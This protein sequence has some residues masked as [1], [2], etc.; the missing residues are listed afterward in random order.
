MQQQLQSLFPLY[1]EILSKLDGKEEVLNQTNCTTITKLDQEHLN[2]I[3][4]LILHHHTINGNNKGDIPYGGRT[5]SN[6]KGITY[7]KLSQLPDD[8]QKIISCYL[9]SITSE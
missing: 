7:R 8:L 4:L 3:Y 2:I 9:T 6:N 5:I 1:D